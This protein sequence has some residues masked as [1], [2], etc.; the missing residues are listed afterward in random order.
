M[1]GQWASS[2]WWPSASMNPMDTSSRHEGIDTQRH[3]GVGAV[4][5]NDGHSE[6][7]KDRNINPPMDPGDNPDSLINSHYWDPLQ[8]SSL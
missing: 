2:L 7:R 3:L 1:V 6:F 8:R 4:V 5:F